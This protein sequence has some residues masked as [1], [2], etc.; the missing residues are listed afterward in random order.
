MEQGQ[1]NLQQATE[2]TA[3]SRHLLAQG[4]VA[5]AC[6]LLLLNWLVA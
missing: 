4:I 2:A 6:L 1:E 3:A 5:M